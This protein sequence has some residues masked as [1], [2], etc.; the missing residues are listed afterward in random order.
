MSRHVRPIPHDKDRGA[1]KTVVN[2]PELADGSRHRT[3]LRKRWSAVCNL[4]TRPTHSARQRKLACRAHG[5][6]L[7]KVQRKPTAKFTTDN[8]RLQGSSRVVLTRRTAKGYCHRAIAT[9]LATG[10]ASVQVA[11]A[12][13]YDARP[14]VRAW[15]FVAPTSSKILSTLRSARAS[16]VAQRDTAPSRFA[17]YRARFD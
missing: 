5:A 14:S 17:P 3:T 11:Q 9:E 4:H 6:R 10:D 16:A 7:D 13:P 15:T 2:A 12:R 8:L 1:D